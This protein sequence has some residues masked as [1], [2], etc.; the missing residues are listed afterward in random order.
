MSV[1]EGFCH[2]GYEEFKGQ[3]L[4]S[5]DLSSL[6]EGLRNNGLLRYSHMLTGKH[7]AT[8]M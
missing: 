6:I 2:T 5:S 8:I 1:R 3:V 7:I 4:D